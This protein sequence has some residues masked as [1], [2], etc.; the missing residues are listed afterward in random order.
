MQQY[1]RLGSKVKA[2]QEQIESIREIATRITPGYSEKVQTSRNT[3]KISM[4]VSKIVDLEN[5]LADEIDKL[6]SLQKRISNH[7]E[8]LTD[9]DYRLLI[10]LRYLSF[11]TWEAIALE[12][13]F[14][15]QWVHVLHKKALNEFQAL[16]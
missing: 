9:D 10:A 14:T 3:D 11:Y 15:V 4:A 16:I 13:D 6:L 5:G 7:V 2:L 8:R 1:K 12:M